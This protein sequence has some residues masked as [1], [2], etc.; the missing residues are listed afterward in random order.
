MV[1]GILLF[2]GKNKEVQTIR[3]IAILGL[4]AFV[5]QIISFKDF[6][7]SGLW[8]SGAVFAAR[9]VAFRDFFPLAIVSVAFNMASL[10]L[11]RSP[12]QKNPIR[13]TK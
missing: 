1:A 9:V 4:L 8:Y 10:W 2:D 6:V 12:S 5:A 7:C 3:L 13:E 11:L